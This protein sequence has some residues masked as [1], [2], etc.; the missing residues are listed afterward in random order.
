MT[1]KKSENNSSN[2]AI[3]TWLIAVLAALIIAAPLG[4]LSR[5]V[6]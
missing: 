4:A 3:E 2:L 6:F 1:C 5:L